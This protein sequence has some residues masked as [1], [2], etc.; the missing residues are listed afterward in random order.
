MRSATTRFPHAT[1]SALAVTLMLLGSGWAEALNI[2]TTGATL[3]T[4]QYLQSLDKSFYM[5]LQE[6]GNLAVR[7]GSGPS[8]HHGVLWHAG[9][10]APGGKYFLVLQTDG[11]L[12]VY[13]GTN[14]RDRGQEVWC[15]MS[16]PPGTG[17]Y[18]LTMQEDGNLAV[19]RG[20]GRA[21]NKGLVWH[22]GM[23]ATVTWPMPGPGKKL[24][25]TSRGFPT[26]LMYGQ[27]AQYGIAKGDQRYPA[28]MYVVAAPEGDE[29][30]LPGDGTLRW[31]P[32]YRMCAAVLFNGAVAAEKC[33][34]SAEQG[35]WQYRAA[36]KTLR[37]SQYPKGC[38]LAALDGNGWGVPNF[39]K[40]RCIAEP[41]HPYFKDYGLQGQWTWQ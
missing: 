29:W 13:V 10:T 1:A 38:L 14:L 22:T 18:F 4:G 3:H 40:D 2:L 6:D 32:N 41:N 7:K 35:G 15:S 26:F 23:T 34:G 24:M 37:K 39:D 5:I 31:G 33:N 19:Y 25:N 27:P 28:R 8:D 21:D 20:S 17:S 11:N 16:R 12:C 30:G 9:R 36:D